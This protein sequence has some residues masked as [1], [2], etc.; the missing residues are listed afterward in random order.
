MPAPCV[1]PTR[2]VKVAGSGQPGGA[3]HASPALYNLVMQNMRHPI[4]PSNLADLELFERAR[5]VLRVRGRSDKNSVG[6]AVR[7]DKGIFIGLDLKSRKS[8]ICAEPGAISAAY[9]AGGYLL[10]SIIAVCKRDEEIFAISPCGACRELLNFHAPDC[11]V[12]F[13][14]EDSWV[15]LKAKELFRYPIIFGL[16]THHSRE[17]RRLREAGK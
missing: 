3:S 16:T 8:A 10:E 14:Y 6:A 11:R 2:E 7:T 15:D 13:G 12:V 5:E 17:A 9:S 4:Y 1:L